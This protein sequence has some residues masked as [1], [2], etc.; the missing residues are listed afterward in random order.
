V[1]KSKDVNGRDWVGKV[2]QNCVR[3]KKREESDAIETI[4]DW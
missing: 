1:T 4:I 2:L 3:E